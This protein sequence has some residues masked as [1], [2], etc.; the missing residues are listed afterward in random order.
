MTTMRKVEDTQIHISGIEYDLDLHFTGQKDS[1]KY[2]ASLTISNKDNGQWSFTYLAL[3]PK[4]LSRLIADL[5][6]MRDYYSELRKAQ[7]DKEQDDA[8]D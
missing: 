7:E 4:C 5:N 2:E 3:D 6:K 8:N 1:P